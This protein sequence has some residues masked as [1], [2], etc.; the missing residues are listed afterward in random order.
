MNISHR[1]LFTLSKTPIDNQWVCGGADHSLHLFT[2]TKVVQSLYESAF[3][4]SDWVTCSAYFDG[5][6][7]GGMDGML[8]YWELK[9]RYKGARMIKMGGP[10]SVIQ[11]DKQVYVGCYDGS[12]SLF[13]NAKQLM[14]KVYCI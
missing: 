10:V 14:S 6:L 13:S 8:S 2:P 4:H 12:V 3:G 1:P 11:A 7:G 5:I 9:G